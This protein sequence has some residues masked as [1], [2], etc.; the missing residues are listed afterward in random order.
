MSL[1]ETDETVSS[2]F[3]CRSPS[4]APPLD[5]ASSTPPRCK[6]TW[7]DLSTSAAW[8]RLWYGLSG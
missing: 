2:V 3:V 1:A 7:S 4:A 5:S 8:T 6:S